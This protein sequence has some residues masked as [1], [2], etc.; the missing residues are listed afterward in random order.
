MATPEPATTRLARALL[1]ETERRLLLAVLGFCSFAGLA[2]S[3]VVG[4]LLGDV[5][6]TFGVSIPVAGQLVAA[7]ALPAALLSL[8]MGPIADRYGRAWLLLFGVLV[9]AAASLAS[10][11]AWSFPVLLV[12]RAVA[13]LGAAALVPATYGAVGDY[14]PPE[15]RGRA[16]ALIVSAN[17]L[18]GILGVPLGALLAQVGNWRW[19]FA[20][21]AIP[22]LAAALLLR[23]RFAPRGAQPAAPRQ[24]YL[25][26][27]RAVLHDPGAV[28]VLAAWLLS[29]TSWFAWYTYVGPFFQQSWGL[30]TGA[31]G[32]IVAAMSVGVL[33]GTN[34]GGRLG[35]AY[36]KPRVAV[37]CLLTVGALTA[38]LP[39]FVTD[40]WIAALV[41]FLLCV[42]NAGRFTTIA[43]IASERA[44]GGRG[45]MFAIGVAAGQ[46]A[47]LLGAGL[48]GLVIELWHYAGLGL[49][50]GVLS[51][52]AAGL[53]VRLPAAPTRSDAAPAT[54]QDNAR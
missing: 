3:L 13:G 48:G 53:L 9:L 35:D 29:S 6:E 54:R 8:V 12:C 15:Q 25:A 1:G 40:F 47:Q 52:I 14:F 33:L 24:D 28:P 50:G 32:P 5:S 23:H 42:P 34:L 46:S 4:P 30:S 38:A 31:L 18:A 43:A 11:I 10:A 20:V 19:T 41:N 16:I 26:G 49:V 36:G 45:T 17:T 22:L 44:P 37:I 21:T 27:Y 39:A 51:W 7:Y 2:A